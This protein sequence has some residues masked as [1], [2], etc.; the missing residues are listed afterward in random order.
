MKPSAALFKNAIKRGLFSLIDK[1]IN[2]KEKDEIKKLFNSRCAYCGK[3][4][5]RPHYDH[6]IPGKGNGK[7]NR[8]LACIYCNSCQKSD[9]DWKDFLKIYCHQSN[10]MSEYKARMKKISKWISKNKYKKD[11]ELD[12]LLEECR[13]EINDIIDKNIKKIKKG[14][15][16]AGADL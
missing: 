13:S 3:I 5:D 15:Q 8:V 14:I 12:E 9:E 16:Q 11:H 4:A 7:Y 10:E 2:D 6:V 1:D